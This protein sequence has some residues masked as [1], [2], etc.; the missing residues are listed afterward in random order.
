MTDLS[1]QEKRAAVF[2]LTTTREGLL[3][4]LEGLTD[5]EWRSRP[6]ADRWSILEVVEH[7][8]IVERRVHGVIG[9]MGAAPEAEPGRR[10][11]EVDQFVLAAV[12]RRDR[13][14]EAPAPIQPKGQW[15]PEE[16]LDQFLAGRKETLELLETADCLRGRL[17]P[18]PLF[19]LWDG[20][21]WILATAAHNARHTGQILEVRGRA[22]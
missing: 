21:Q 10:N 16:A 9:R 17:L 15:S 12:A 5:H 19:G 20:Y 13:P 8:A 22:I 7:L 1:L 6:A 3:E 14:V 2:H 4:A 18:H 11:S